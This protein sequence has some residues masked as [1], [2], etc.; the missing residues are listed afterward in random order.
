MRFISLIFFACALPL[1]AVQDFDCV[2][3]SDL[4][5]PP[6]AVSRLYEA[7]AFN[8]TIPKVNVVTG[9]YCEEERDFV[10]AGA[11]P[12]SIRR[13]YNHQGYKD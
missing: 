8:P 5:P 11:Q 10:V 2:S 1:C 7:Q 6:P 3:K 4:H 9:E 12:L 13:F